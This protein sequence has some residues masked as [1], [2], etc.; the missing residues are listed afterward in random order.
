M[1]TD[2]GRHAEGLEHP[3]SYTASSVSFMATPS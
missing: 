3:S 1:F 2:A